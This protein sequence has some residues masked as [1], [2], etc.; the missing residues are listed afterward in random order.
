MFRVPFAALRPRWAVFLFLF[1]GNLLAP[2]AGSAASLPPLLRVR[3]VAPD[4][5]VPTLYS[6]PNGAALPVATNGLIIRTTKGILLIDTAW[7]TEQ[8]RQLLRWVA[9]SLHQRVRRAIVTHAGAATPGGLVVLRENHVRV[10]SSPLT[11]RRWRSRNPA[12]EGPTAA[13]KPYTVVRAGRTRVELF[14]PGAGFAPDNLVAWLPRR[15]VLFGGELVREQAT[16]SLGSSPEPNLKQWSIAL[17]TLATRY[18][19]AR[20]IVPAHGPA[21]S[22]TLLAHTQTLLHEATR[23]KP[24]TALNG[25]P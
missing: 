10:Y 9:D 6:R 25:R 13:L 18:R 3:P 14:F 19:N 5:F 2:L 7:P 23:R 17:R 24:Q 8:T 12:A 16:A 11:A 15:R 22:L 20:V 21:G 4:I 1:A